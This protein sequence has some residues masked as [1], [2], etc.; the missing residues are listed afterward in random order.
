MDPSRGAGAAAPAAAC[1]D[2]VG[3]MEVVAARAFA[4]GAEL[5]ENACAGRV[6][7]MVAAGGGLGPRIWISPSPSPGGERRRRAGPT[8]RIREPSTAIPAG[9]HGSQGPPPPWSR[10]SSGGPMPFP[11]GER[12]GVRRPTP[13]WGRV[14]AYHP[15]MGFASGARCTASPAASDGQG[16]DPPPRIPSRRR[17]AAVG[18]SHCPPSSQGPSLGRGTSC[19]HS[20]ERRTHRR[21]WKP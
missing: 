18:P 21:P 5:V 15:P 7:F 13:R 3:G 16:G 4:G 11:G 6:R 10:R 2:C 19:L 1:R 12:W 20:G 8:S 14:A 17:A 9:G